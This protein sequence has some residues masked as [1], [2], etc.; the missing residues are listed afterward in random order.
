MLIVK[1]NDLNRAGRRYLHGQISKKCLEL[2]EIN[3]ND[4]ERQAQ[5]AARGQLMLGTACRLVLN[6]TN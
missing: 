3:K 2:D 1:V 4:K 6:L 5:H